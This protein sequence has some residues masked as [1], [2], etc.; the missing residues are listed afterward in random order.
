MNP[1]SGWKAARREWPALL[2]AMGPEAVA[3]ESFWTERR[4]H[5]ELLAASAR[6]AGYDRVIAVGGG[7]T[8]FEVLNGLWRERSGE[9]PSVGMVPF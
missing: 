6:R 4:W 5:A 2:R 8:L 7:G 9:L 3:V 1:V